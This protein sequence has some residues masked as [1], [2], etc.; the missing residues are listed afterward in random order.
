MT[1]SD[2]FLSG[3]GVDLPKQDSRTAENVKRTAATLPQGTEASRKA[4]RLSASLLTRNFLP[5]TLSQAGL[6]GI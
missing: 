3:G 4:K 5:P 1:E 6:L 2:D